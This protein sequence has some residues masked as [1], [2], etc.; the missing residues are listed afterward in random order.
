MGGVLLVIVGCLF[1]GCG[2]LEVWVGR[3]GWGVV[4]IG[5]GLVSVFLWFW[6]VR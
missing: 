3:L 1:F 6:V 2:W 4:I 5:S